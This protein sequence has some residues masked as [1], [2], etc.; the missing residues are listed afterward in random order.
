MSP[1]NSGP[2]TPSQAPQPQPQPSISP[3]AQQ[4]QRATNP[5]YQR[6]EINRYYARYPGGVPSP[7]RSPQTPQKSFNSPSPKRPASPVSSDDSFSVN[8]PG[9]MPNYQENIIS[10]PDIKPIHYS[11][12]KCWCQV[13]ILKMLFS[14]NV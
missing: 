14:S 7:P 12:P 11:E 13:R 6:A 10:H 3:G 9:T 4:P 2:P 8:S 1:Y 5:N